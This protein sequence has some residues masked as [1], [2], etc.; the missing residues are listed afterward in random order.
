MGKKYCDTCGK[1]L[2]DNRNNDW[3]TTCD[4][5]YVYKKKCCVCQVDLEKIEVNHFIILISDIITDE[6]VN[7]GIKPGL[8]KI[9]KKEFFSEDIYGRTSINEDSVMW[10]S[11]I[12]EEIMNECGGSRDCCDECA[13][14][15][16]EKNMVNKGW[17]LS[18]SLT[19]TSDL[20]M[21]SSKF[22]ENTK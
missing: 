1:E 8:Y 13:G 4:K 22:N 15:I 17:K 6:V 10:I 9:L 3:G 7:E 18:D 21:I 16:K 20:C 2:S 19:V 11:D 12:D 5:C 14:K